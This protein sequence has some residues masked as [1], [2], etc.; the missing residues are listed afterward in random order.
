MRPE[1]LAALRNEVAGSEIV[2]WPTCGVC[3][4]ATEALGP[5][6]ERWVPVEAY[7][8]EPDI[9][10]SVPLLGSREG[11]PGPSS[12]RA[13]GKLNPSR[14]VGSRGWFVIIAEC[15]HGKGPG[16]LVHEQRAEV[17]VPYWWGVFHLE[18]RIGTL[19]FFGTSGPERPAM[20]GDMT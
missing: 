20:R 18:Q 9:I 14:V 3:T 5:E 10:V 2:K 19:T 17:D 4:S 13:I 12:T 8:V 6:W 1:K 16:H 11:L 15:T 7:R